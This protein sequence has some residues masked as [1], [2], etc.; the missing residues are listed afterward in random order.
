M[1][2]VFP[3]DHVDDLLE[4]EPNQPDLAPAIPEPALVEE[5]EEPKKE[6]EF[7]D[8]E[9]FEEEEPQEEE[10]MEVDI[11]E[12]ENELEL[13]FPYEEAD[14]L[15]LLPPASDSESED[16][17][18]V[19]DMV[20]PKDETVPNSVHKVG[21]SS[22][23]TFLREDGD[24]SI[25]E[26]VHALV[27]NKGKAK[28]K[29]YGKLI[30]DLGN[31]VRC[32]VGEREAILED[33]IKEFGNVEERVEGKKLKK[34]LE[35]TRLRNTLLRFLLCHDRIMPPKS[36]PLT[37]AAIERM[38]TSRVNEALAANQARRV[39]AD[40]AGGFRQGGALAA[41]P[42]LTWWNSK[43]ATMGLEVVN[44]IPWN[45]MKQLMIAEFCP[46]EKAQW[47]E[48]ELWNL[49]VKEFN[50]NNQK[51]GNARAMTTA[52][53]KSNAPTSPLPLCDRCFVRHSRLCHKCGK[54]GH[55][56][57]YYKEKNVATGA[58]A[59][60]IW[61][62][63]DCGEQGHTRNHFP[64]KNKSQGGNASGRAYVIKDAD[65]QRPN[66]VTGTC[67]LNNRYASVLFDSGSCKSFVNTNFSHLI[68]INP[69]KL[70]V[71]YEVEIADGK[72]VSTNTVLRGCT[73]N[74]VNHLFKIDLMPIELGTFDIILG[75]DC[76]AERD[77]VIVCGKKV[78]R[79]PFGNKTLIVEGDKG[80]S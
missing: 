10:N 78:I 65:K 39:N 49:K 47:M 46:A 51:Q 67:L 26:T 73:L 4:V 66:V 42:A 50:I 23:T 30:A 68:D 21:E 59:Q 44:Q 40:E 54:V 28:D 8:Q 27:K 13:T 32:S 17:V 43:V 48:H 63:Y 2:N 18:V 25:R 31:E 9:E 38:I 34:E 71:S 45:E 33:L 74:L 72:V 37:H 52:P 20:E 80:P 36:R 15:N 19:K 77:A 70:D 60:P 41:R 22:T 58:N 24:M 7:E 57:R 14:P 76:L 62:C 5:N 69:D 56:A 79:I 53:N 35:E 11:R 12:E 3:P 75:M 55:K 6:E 29:Y 1:V 16:V 64:K 61:T